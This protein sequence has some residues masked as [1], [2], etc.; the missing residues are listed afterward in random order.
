[1]AVLE[2]ETAR[3]RLRKLTPDDLNDLSAIRADSDVMRYIGSGKPESIEQVR[4]TLNN[5]L[6][7]W[8][9]HGFGRW[10]VVYKEANRLIGWCGLRYLEST[11]EVEIGYGVAKSHWGK[12]LTLEAATASIKCGFDELSLDRIVALALPDNIISRRVMDRL[13]MKYV[14]V[15]HYYHAEVVYYAIS[16]DEYRMDQQRAQ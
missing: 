1:V 12:G 6:A 16:R 7:H 5:I 4:T 2:I 11:G 14:K 15:A 3:L 8:G 13:G 10:A 9:Q